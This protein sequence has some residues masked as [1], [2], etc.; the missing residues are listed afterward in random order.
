M[1]SFGEDRYKPALKE[2]W[3]LCFPTDTRI[4]IDFYFDKVY[5]NDET[6]IYF[7]NGKTA[8]AFQ[9]IPYTLKNGGH[10]AQAGYIYGA[11][12][13]PDFR[14]KGFMKNLLFAAFDI[15][16]ER[17]LDYTFLIPQ[18][19]WLFD[20]YAKF[21]YKAILPPQNFTNHYENT[22]YCEPCTVYRE[23]LSI[24]HE[25][26]ITYSRFLSAIPQAILKTENQF[27]QII[28][29]F[30]D[31]NG[32]LFACRQGI[33]FT[34]QENNSIVVKELFYR[35]RQVKDLFLK[36]ICDYYSREEIVIL[37][38]SDK[39]AGLRGMIKRLNDREPDI[40]ELYINMMLDGSHH[41][42]K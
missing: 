33:A 28:R 11:M 5:K 14:R 36:V 15:M 9:M 12:T 6:L 31:E 37:N 27:Q 16:R 2:M 23:P 8:A 26:Y 7:E 42:Q 10:T 39:P 4:F 17:R 25:I 22:A 18:E 21:G 24:P 13:H 35:N 3:K 1:I 34:F 41:T 32:V 40:S 19:A 30:F 20:F 38:S 29:D